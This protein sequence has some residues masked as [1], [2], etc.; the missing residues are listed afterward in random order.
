MDILKSVEEEKELIQLNYFKEN[1][2]KDKINKDE[3]NIYDENKMILNSDNKFKN[4]NKINFGRK[5]IH[6]KN[7]SMDAIMLNKNLVIEIP[8]SILKKKFKSNNEYDNSIKNVEKEYQYINKSSDNS[9]LFNK[10]YNL[11]NNKPI[12]YFNRIPIEDNNNNKSKFG[13]FGSLLAPI[14]LTDYDINSFEKEKKK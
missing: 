8:N 3:I 7:N 11:L 12:K 10:F 14:F 5:I 2:N 13:F 6:K 1:N 9:S 4:K